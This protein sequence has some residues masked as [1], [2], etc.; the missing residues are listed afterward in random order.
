VTAVRNLTVNAGTGSVTLDGAV[1]GSNL[2]NAVDITGTA[3]ININGGSVTSQSTQDYNSLVVL[4]ADTTFTAADANVAFDSTISGVTA[5]RNL[6]IGAGTGSITIDGVVGGSDLINTIDLTGAGGIA[7]N[8]GSVTSQSTQDYNS[9]V[10]I[11]ADTSFTAANANITFDNTVQGTTTIRNLTVDAGTG[12]ITLSGAVG[13][14]NLINAVDMTGSAGLNLDGGS[15]T[16]QST[17]DYHSTVSLGNDLTLTTA[18]ADVTFDQT[19]DGGQKLTANT[20][21]GDVTFSDAVGSNTTVAGMMINA[22]NVGFASTVDVDSQGLD[23]TSSGTVDFNDA[24]TT[25]S[26]GD[27]TINN[28]GTMTA[29][30]AADFVVDGNFTQSGTGAVTTSA[31]MI[32]H[33]GDV[34][35]NGAVTL[36]AEQTVI[37][38]DTG[39]ITFNSSLIDT[40]STGVIDGSLPKDGLAGSQILLLAG[41]LATGTVATIADVENLTTLENL[42]SD[43]ITS[44]PSNITVGAVNVAD[45]NAYSMALTGRGGYLYGALTVAGSGSQGQRAAESVLTTPAPHDGPSQNGGLYLN[46]YLITGQSVAERVILPEPKVD[47]SSIGKGDD[48]IFVIEGE[49]KTEKTG[50]ASDTG[51]GITGDEEVKDPC[52]SNSSADGQCASDQP[53]NTEEVEEKDGGTAGESG[54]GITGE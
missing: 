25:T 16:S 45:V 44:T 28:T 3:G 23:V 46:G 47:E 38:T 15:I 20:G 51:F 33:G 1:G 2:I 13:G 12:A 53:E 29:A 18:N 11:G 8:G 36:D 40:D 5:V 19:V 27:I 37:M 49:Q 26:A 42:L 31:N 6:T 34:T 21:T 52:K 30:A 35:F 32:T 17:Q 39:N 41:S 4:G 7:L 14:S 50:T 9:D 43:A 24:V 54:Y 10:T 22:G 48:D